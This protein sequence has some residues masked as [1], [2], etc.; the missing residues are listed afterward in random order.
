[1]KQYMRASEREYIRDAN[2][3]GMLTNS[4]L[5]RTKL[6]W[7][8]ATCLLLLGCLDRAGAD[9]VVC[10]LVSGTW[11]KANSP[12]I[13]TC[14]ILA[15][16]LKIEPGV[17]VS[18]SNYTFEVA[19]VLTAIGTEA[20]PIVFNAR[21]P[22]VGWQGIFFNYSS[23]GS[24]MR[25][26]IVSNAVNSGVRIASVLPYFEH[27]TFAN[28]TSA[29]GSGGA[30]NA[31]IAAGDLV[32]SYCMFASNA[33]AAGNGGG[34]SANIAAGDLVLSY[35][36]FT[37]NVSAVGSGGGIYANI[38]TGDLV[39][40]YCTNVNNTARYSGGGI[41]AGV[42]SSNT[43][44]LEFCEIQ[45]NAANPGAGGG[46]DYIGGG[47]SIVG[48]LQMRNCLVASNSVSGCTWYNGNYASGGGVYVQGY[49]HVSN[50]IFTGNFAS[51]QPCNGVPSAYGGGMSSSG[52][53]PL[54]VVN[55]FFSYNTATST[56]A[57]YGGGLY[58]HSSVNSPGVVNCTF[59][60]NNIEGLYSSTSAVV[61]NSILFFNNSGTTQIVGATNVTY[62]DVQ[63]GFTGAG[64]IG[65]QPIFQ[66]ATNLAIAPGSRCID[67]GSPNPA[68]NDV[69]LSPCGP[70]LG[71][72][73]NDMGA[74]GG[75][76]AC[77]W[78]LACAPS[79][80]TQPRDQIGC[81]GHAA[82]FTVSAS[83]SDSLS[84]Q[85]Y[86]NTNTLI[87][88][89]TNASLTLTN[90]RGTNAGKYSVVVSSP[91]SSVTSSNAQ[92]TIYDPYTELEVEWYFDAY[93]YAGLYIGGQPGA[94][95]VV[96]YTDDLRNTN[97]ATWTPMVTNTMGSS[98]WFPY[99][100][101]ESPYSP[102]RFYQARRLP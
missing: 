87:V 12:Y 17:T 91:Y 35:C 88:N 100:D 25:Y 97:W 5:G 79:I 50:C 49:A 51:A 58:I 18:A 64:N 37:N 95:Y 99:V 85:W 65:F 67:A 98:G 56:Y 68:F 66:S 27:C 47:V 102:M 70:S 1:M 48:G 83:G 31:N 4:L 24:E 21:N 38:T 71:T 69:C 8:V 33:S 63:N 32:L 3:A 20:E 7:R 44:I 45:R 78:A 46:G 42:S 22:A 62:C 53:G 101:E 2:P 73:T 54:T 77:G 90:L 39:M 57:S 9:T 74:T 34:I 93:M 59:A 55:S 96:K 40:R 26:C 10:G 19:G 15:V 61:M 80:D 23:P 30:I 75:P 89:A 41:Y 11:T 81:L 14:D 16:D 94:T 82:T 76:G 72:V 13:L 36:S 43:L 28:N 84:Y 6:F 60:Y 92:L 86:F 52:A 29:S